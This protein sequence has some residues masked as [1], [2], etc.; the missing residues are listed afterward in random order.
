LF[1]FEA[2]KFGRLIEH[3]ER[4]AELAGGLRNYRTN[5]KRKVGRYIRDNSASAQESGKQ[6]SAKAT[7]RSQGNPPITL[8]L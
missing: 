2:S 7:N 4:I 1:G 3:D 6:R 8:Q 5:G